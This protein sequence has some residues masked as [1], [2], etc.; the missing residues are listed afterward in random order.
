[1][2]FLRSRAK[3]KDL[4]IHDSDSDD[5]TP[6]Q[7][8]KNVLYRTT[9]TALRNSQHLVGTQIVNPK[10]SQER[11]NKARDA[12]EALKGAGDKMNIIKLLSNLANSPVTDIVPASAASQGR[13]RLDDLPSVPKVDHAAFAAMPSADNQT[14]LIRSRWF[15]KAKA[16]AVSISD[17]RNFMPI[18]YEFPPHP[19]GDRSNEWF[20]DQYARL[21]DRIAGFAQDFFAYHDLQTKFHEP[22]AVDMPDE[23]YR[24][25][26]L[27]A[28][29]DPAVGGWDE[30]LE[31]TETRKFLIVG[32]IV[33]ILEV[34]VF[35]PNLWGNTREGEEL[36]H[37]LDR[38]LLDSEGMKDSLYVILIT[39]LY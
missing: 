13:A 6:G 37:N 21:F 20:Q 17:F 18:Q 4:S 38:A 12:L 5:E 10:L 14:S 16:R 33:R 8:D 24:Y 29:P 30:M 34:K 26:E 28:E 1:M 3:F 19:A 25:V 15:G 36:L 23:F 22:W 35:A 11:R 9:G 39:V 2:S 27:V 31:D 7:A 32:I